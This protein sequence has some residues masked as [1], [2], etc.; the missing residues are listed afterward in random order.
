MIISEGAPVQS[1]E[2]QAWYHDASEVVRKIRG[3]LTANEMLNKSDV[4]NS[5][6][7]SGIT[8]CCWEIVLNYYI[9]QAVIRN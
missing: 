9:L 2:I 5:V 3:N 8:V 6:K 4:S 1:S 7:P